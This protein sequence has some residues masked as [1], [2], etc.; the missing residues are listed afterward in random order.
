MIQPAYPI[1]ALSVGERMWDTKGGRD[2]APAQTQGRVGGTRIHV[3][4]GLSSLEDRGCEA[5]SA[6]DFMVRL[7]ARRC[8]TGGFCHAVSELVDVVGEV[9]GVARAAARGII[10][11][12]ANS[13]RDGDIGEGRSKTWMSRLSRLL[14]VWMERARRLGEVGALFGEFLSHGEF[15]H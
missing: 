9:R 6:E 10:F 5:H 12:Q 14:A 3:D 2:N 1:L 7:C 15:T 8:R 13:W 11:A 4:D